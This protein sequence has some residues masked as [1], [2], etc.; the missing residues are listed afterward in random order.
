MVATAAAI[1]VGDW[2]LHAF[3][4]RSGNRRWRFAPAGGGAGLF[5]G[6]SAGGRIYA[7]SPSGR[8]HAIDLGDGREIWSA[9]VDGSGRSSVF[10][11][12]TD[13]DVVV[14]GYTTFTA[15]NTGGVVAVA[16]ATGAERW[17]FRFPSPTDRSLSVNSAGDPVL[18]RD[19]AIASSGD[20]QVWALDRANGDVRWTLPRLSGPLR[21]II[22]SADREFRPLAIAQGRLIVGS[23]TGHVLAYDI[24]SQAE[25]WRVEAGWLGSTGFVIGADEQRIYVPFVSGFLMA[26]D[27]SSGS[28]AWR[29]SDHELG[30]AWPPAVAA[31]RVVVAGGS[32][33]WAFPRR[34]EGQ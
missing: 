4:P 32:G 20:G 26:I 12:V 18:T 24:A 21:G 1:V 13:G 6:E 31:D 17:R 22:T 27:A 8:L 29:T 30:L 33:V 19:L 16:A 25:V 10:P 11:P 5:L 2:D 9:V 14:A 34:L 15:P 28:V 3:D 7:G 23:L